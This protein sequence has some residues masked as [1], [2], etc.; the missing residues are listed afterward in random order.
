MT[1]S[2]R[3]ARNKRRRDKQAFNKLLV[4][5]VPKY[6]KKI[7]EELNWGPWTP[8]APTIDKLLENEKRILAT[9]LASGLITQE[10][11]DL[12]RKLVEGAR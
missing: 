5:R 2:Q 9:L 8:F 7:A 11:V 1:P 4:D 6:D 10:Q 12:A 3:D